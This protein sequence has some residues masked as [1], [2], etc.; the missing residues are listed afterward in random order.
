[1]G[2]KGL[3][4]KIE[5]CKLCESIMFNGFVNVSEKPYIKY[6]VYEERV[7]N[8]IKCLFIAESPPGDVN[9]FFYYPYTDNFLRKRLLRFLGIHADGEDGLREF[10]R[11]GYFLIDVVEC[12]VNKV[13]KGTIPREVINNCLKFLSAKIEL[14][15]TRG[16]K[17]IVILG[18]T[19]IQALKELGF[20]ELR[21]KSVAKNC[22]EVVESGEF[23]VFLL[24]LPA[25]RGAKYIKQCYTDE[26]GGQTSEIPRRKLPS[27]KLDCGFTSGFSG[28]TISTLLRVMSP[29]TNNRHLD[30]HQTHSPRC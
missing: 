30:L 18:S 11:R 12:R 17:K 5:S 10:K 16:A 15:R 2:L 24:P 6:K 20:N 14:A 27:S 4:K 7:P 1:M 26:A 3:I 22:G 8:T 9:T 29:S 21:E 19:A 25:K 28:N 23:K 13:G